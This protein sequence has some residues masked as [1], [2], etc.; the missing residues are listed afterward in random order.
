MWCQKWLPEALGLC[1]SYS[2][3]NW[4]KEWNTSYGSI[5]HSGDD[6]SH[7]KYSGQDSGVQG[8]PSG[9]HGIRVE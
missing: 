4:N 5:K 9:P 8:L 3:A 1:G 7:C 6:L 2:N